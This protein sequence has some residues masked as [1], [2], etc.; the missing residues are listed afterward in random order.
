[1]LQDELPFPPSDSRP[2]PVPAA[3]T[4]NLGD[5]IGLGA[6]DYYRISFALGQLAREFCHGVLFCMRSSLCCNFVAIRNIGMP[7]F[8]H[9]TLFFRIYVAIQV[10]WSLYWREATVVTIYLPVSWH[11]YVVCQ[12]VLKAPKYS[13]LSQ[14]LLFRDLPVA[15][16]KT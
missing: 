3:F 9:S 8:I 6:E 5:F 4:N 2:H 15:P 1:M 7:R 13:L 11:I 16:S 14:L 10:V 12:M